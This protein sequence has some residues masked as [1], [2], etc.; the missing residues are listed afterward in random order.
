MYVGVIVQ[1]YFSSG[2]IE[3]I[4]VKANK[5]IVET[6]DDDDDYEEEEN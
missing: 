3:F 5:Q 6:K 2:M 4:Y 1:V